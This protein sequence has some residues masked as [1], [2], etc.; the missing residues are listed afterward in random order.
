MTIDDL[1][2]MRKFIWKDNKMSI[3]EF[4]RIVSYQVLRSF[5]EITLKTAIPGFRLEDFINCIIMECIVRK[6]CND[7]KRSPLY[8][9]VEKDKDNT[10]SLIKKRQRLFQKVQSE[11]EDYQIYLKEKYNLDA[12]ELDEFSKVSPQMRR[13]GY[14]LM[15]IQHLNLDTREQLPILKKIQKGNMAS[16]KNYTYADFTNDMKEYDDFVKKSISIEDEK[17]YILN[18]V[19]LYQIEWSYAIE[20]VYA[21]CNYM[22]ENSIEEVPKNR[23]K[24][25][26]GHIVIGGQ[27]IYTENRFVKSRKWVVHMLFD[28]EQYEYLQGTI[29]TCLTAK[30]YLFKCIDFDNTTLE[31][32][33]CENIPD[34]EIIRFLKNTYNWG[35]IFEEKVWTRK[36]AGLFKQISD[37]I[38]RKARPEEKHVML[39]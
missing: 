31:K 32:F 33:F 12:P 5:P 29:A 22:D 19:N 37:D 9:Y 38:I 6:T 30:L 21:I 13:G 28:D 36:K 35:D 4:K 23:V 34:E 27:P 18:I 11:R 10:E 17:D 1:E 39:Q 16:K 3:Y 20:L 7:I 2:E 15:D 8:A 25:L 24:T 14:G 26:C